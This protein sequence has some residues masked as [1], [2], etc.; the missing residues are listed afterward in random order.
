MRKRRACEAI[1]FRSSQLHAR[2]SD[3]RDCRDGVKTYGGGGKGGD[4]DGGNDVGGVE[5]DVG[6]DMFGN[7]EDDEDDEDEDEEVL[8]SQD[9][10]EII[11][12]LIRNGFGRRET[13]PCF[14]VVPG[15]IKGTEVSNKL[16][17]REFTTER[18]G[19]QGGE[20]GC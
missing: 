12:G 20:L 9:D 8:V 2:Q 6:D 16:G 11:E 14:E 5:S 18:C 19:D 13:K 17:N 10:E 7:E 15:M 4:G 3:C 1:A